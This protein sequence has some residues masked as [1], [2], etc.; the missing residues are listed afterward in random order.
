MSADLPSPSGPPDP[1]RDPKP[2]ASNEAVEADLWN[3]DEAMPAKTSAAPSPRAM[4]RKGSGD[5]PDQELSGLSERNVQRGKTPARSP[6]RMKED[7]PLSPQAS[8]PVEDDI[9]E[10]D[11]KRP[12]GPGEEDEAVLVVLPEEEAETWAPAPAAK[13]PPEPETVAESPAAAP[14]EPSEPAPRRNRAKEPAENAASLLKSPSRREVIS[15]AAFAFFLLLTAIWVIS[16]FFSQL[17]FES[18][19][20]QSPEYPVQGQHATIARGDT[21]WRAP[22]REGPDRDVARREV[23]MIPVLELTLDTDHSSLGAL[24]IIFRNSQGTPVGDSITRSFTR[25]RFDATGESRIAFPSTDGFIEEGSFNG[26]R[27]QTEDPWVVE[28]LEGPSVDAPANAFRKLAEIPILPQR[29]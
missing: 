18:A 15:L 6:E 1:E 21:Y 17:H 27:T 23:V 20:L 26:Y 3:L 5:H 10:L 28:V 7:H 11:E 4:G 9:G 16:R 24:R 22:V 14:D 13:L 19:A 2:E 29:R 25:G 8:R 12:P